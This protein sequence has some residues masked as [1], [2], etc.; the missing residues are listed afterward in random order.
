[1]KRALL[2]LAFMLG[3][4]TGVPTAPALPEP[5]DEP[6]LPPPALAT[7]PPPDVEGG[8]AAYL[9]SW[10]KGDFAGMYGLLTPLSQD[11]IS[12]QQFVETYQTVEKGGAIARVETALLSS[13]QQDREA[14]TLFK[15]TLHTTL[16]GKIEREVTM[17]LRFENGRWGWIG[18]TA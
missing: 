10:E 5:P 15:V 4:C 9:S 16:V 6:T 7:Q 8:A 11:A 17:P 2:A 1:M 3:A 18:T 12:L 14:Q 13:R